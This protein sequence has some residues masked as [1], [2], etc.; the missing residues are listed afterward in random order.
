VR[1]VSV[2]K[3]GLLVLASSA[4]AAVLLL[5]CV[6]EIIRPPGVQDAT[7]GRLLPITSSKSPWWLLIAVVLLAVWFGARAVGKPRGVLWGLWRWG[8]RIGF[9]WS[10]VAL[11]L[12]AGVA[13][14]GAHTRSIADLNWR[15]ALSYLIGSVAI[16]IA[17]GIGRVR[18]G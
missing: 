14:H 11:V 5:V 3:E 17:C 7:L 4:A 12:F 13:I 2:V 16:L 18:T 6:Q 9:W 1:T 8:V 10:A 15:F